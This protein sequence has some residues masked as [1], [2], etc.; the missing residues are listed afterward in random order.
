[1]SWAGR[2]RALYGGGVIL[3][4]IA[5]LGIPSFFL[6][7]E[8][9]SCSDGVQNQGELGVDRGGPCPLLHES[10]VRRPAVLWARSFRVVPGVYNAV[11]YV[12]NPNF[13]AGALEVPYSFKL[14]DED[15]LLI[16]EREGTTFISPNGTTPIFE[17]GIETGVRT[18]V[19][20]FFEFSGAPTWERVE[21]STSGLKVGTRTLSNESTA[22][23][24]DAVIENNSFEDLFDV[25]VV[26]TIFDSSGTAIASSRSVL[27]VL[28]K[29]T[30]QKV[31]FTWPE[32][33][34]AP[35]AEIEIIPRT[36][37]R[38]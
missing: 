11:A 23:R 35:A 29:K 7:Y 33:F 13:N 28:R 17:G 4:L 6:F 27:D 31:V 5:V 9:P 19:R 34:T 25:E 12:A 32:T 38:R 24:I 20:T 21:G 10:E 37:F 18:P 22:P 1:M 2:R 15:N 36:P 30:S 16:V 8:R 26:A 3:F 14:F